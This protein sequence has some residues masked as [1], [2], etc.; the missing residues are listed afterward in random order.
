MTEV[1]QYFPGMQASVFLEVLDGYG[2][3]ADSSTTP[4]VDRVILPGYTL[5]NGYPQS[6]NRLDVGLYTFQFILPSGAV[7]IGSYLVDV[8]YTNPDD[9]LTNYQ[10]YQIIVT[11]PFGNFGVTT[12]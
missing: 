8:S 6:M 2:G 10:I 5:A 3:R 11:A 1:L 9:F 7:S 4:M 12:F